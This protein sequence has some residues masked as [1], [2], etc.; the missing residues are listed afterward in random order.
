MRIIGDGAGWPGQVRARAFSC[1]RG[2][3]TL[4]QFQEK[5]IAVFRW[6]LRQNK[7]LERFTVALRRQNA[8]NW[9]LGG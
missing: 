4:E 2:K 7:E 5:C 1:E 8:Q 6:E 9:A 3:N